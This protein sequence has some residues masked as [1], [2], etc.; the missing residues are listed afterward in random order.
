[1]NKQITAIEVIKLVIKR[2][3]LSVVIPLL[4]TLVAFG[5]LQHH[6]SSDKEYK[7]TT[8]IILTS[9]GDG[10]NFQERLVAR[11]YDSDSIETLKDLI[12]N[13]SVLSEA[14]KSVKG[15]QYYSKQNLMLKVVPG[16]QRNITLTNNKGSMIV[17]I[18]YVASSAL[19]SK[20]MVNAIANETKKMEQEIYGTNSVKILKK[21]VTP[22]HP[23]SKR[24]LV[25]QL[26]I[27]VFVLTLLAMVYYIVKAG[28]KNGQL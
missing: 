6:Y 3:K 26:S 21:A 18:G 4:A 22:L 28:I 9:G 16:V 2:W 23:D 27:I 20:Q 11:T 13:P 5:V 10:E 24:L 14:V 12:K 1:M 7:S 8:S 19:E 17:A 25:I 15:N